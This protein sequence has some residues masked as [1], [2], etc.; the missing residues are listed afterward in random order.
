MKETLLSIIIPMYNLEQYISYCLDSIV[1]QAN[2]NV[3]IILIDDG[4]KDKTR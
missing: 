4:S 3:E 1:S 2:E